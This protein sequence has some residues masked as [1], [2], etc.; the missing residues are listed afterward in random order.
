MPLRSFVT[1]PLRFGGLFLTGDA[2][3]IVLPT[4]AK[5]LNLATTH[6]MHTSLTKARSTHGFNR[7]SWIA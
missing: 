4:G 5:G 2:G 7:P 6:V 1:K 3:H